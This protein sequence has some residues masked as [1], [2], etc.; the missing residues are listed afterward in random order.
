[1]ERGRCEQRAGC[2]DDMAGR[3]LSQQLRRAP[4]RLIKNDTFAMSERRPR[5]RS[6][7]P[8]LTRGLCIIVTS[9]FARRSIG[10][11]LASPNQGFRRPSD[12]RASS[13][14]CCAVTSTLLALRRGTMFQTQPLTI[15]AMAMDMPTE[16]MVQIVRRARAEEVASRGGWMVC[17]CPCLCARCRPLPILEGSSG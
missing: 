8:H 14:A 9:F 17:V 16:P 15:P 3:R 7:T 2:G 6:R 4:T 13:A 5:S 12:T 1:M 11:C 10:R